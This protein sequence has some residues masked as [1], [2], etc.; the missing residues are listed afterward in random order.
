MAAPRQLQGAPIGPSVN[1][2]LIR[3]LCV[4]LALGPFA[5]VAMAVMLVGFRCCQNPSWTTLAMYAIFQ[6]ALEELIF[7]GLLQDKLRKTKWGRRGNFL[8]F[9]NLATSV[10]FA[11]L[12][13]PSHPPGW[14]A[15]TFFPSLVFGY[16]GDRYRSIVWP[17]AV[18]GFYNLGYLLISP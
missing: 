15:A 10:C 5:W 6:P 8:T 7:R 13:L 16:F 12:H 2:P 11:V 4:A 1:R 14:A 9:A 3:D 17:I 18:H